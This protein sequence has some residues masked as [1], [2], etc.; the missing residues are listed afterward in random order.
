MISQDFVGKFIE[1]MLFLVKRKLGINQFVDN[2]CVCGFRL[3]RIP[4]KCLVI[5]ENKCRSCHHCC[6]QL[7]ATTVKSRS[8]VSVP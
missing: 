5:K 2:V 4:F 3:N 1:K 7:R 6:V 8:V